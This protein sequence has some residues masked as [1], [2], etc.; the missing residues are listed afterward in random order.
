MWICHC[1]TVLVPC[2][3]RQQ[4]ILA[5][6]FAEVAGFRL[7][8]AVIF[9]YTLLSCHTFV[10][11][12][13]GSF[14]ICSFMYSELKSSQYTCTLNTEKIFAWLCTVTTSLFAVM[15]V[16]DIQ[17]TFIHCHMHLF[18]CQ[19]REYSHLMATRCKCRCRSS[20]H[21]NI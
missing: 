5:V 7:L 11:T 12:D 20:V 16:C 18:T 1:Y 13:T 14:Y 4:C 10:C 2:R 17:S 3:H 9:S 21:C 8:F 19:N 15:D 6:M